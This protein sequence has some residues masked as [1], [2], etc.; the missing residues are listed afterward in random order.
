M[1]RKPLDAAMLR[2]VLLGLIVL[3][4]GLGIGGTWYLQ[5][6]LDEKM[7]STNKVKAEAA[8]SNSSLARAQALKIYLQ[9][10][11][12]DVQKTAQIV[13]STAAYKYQDQIVEDI[14]RYAKTAG[15]KVLGFEFPIAASNNKQ[16]TVPG[17]NSITA[18][19]T[20]DNPVLYRDYVLFLKLIEQN[21]TKMQITDISITPDKLNPNLINNP[22]V[23]L[24]VYI[25][26]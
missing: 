13:A 15:L 7:S 14:T 6:I 24:E 3:F 21:L 20:L 2:W 9:N 1:K 5:G 23:G 10:H 8:N 19:V 18:S 17:V 22:V 25:K 12:T 4:V 26:S 16:V 11:Q